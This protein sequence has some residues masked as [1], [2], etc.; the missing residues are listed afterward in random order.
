MGN[1][2]VARFSQLLRSDRLKIKGRKKMCKTKSQKQL[3]A[4]LIIA[5]T[6]SLKTRQQGICPVSNSKRP[7][8]RATRRKQY[9]VPPLR[10][11]SL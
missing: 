10:S 9:S 3:F 2:P 11:A 5:I 8:N 7:H 6:L 1:N 4:K